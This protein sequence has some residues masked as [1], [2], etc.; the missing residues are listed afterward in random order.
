MLNLSPAQRERVEY[1]GTHPAMSRF[2]ILS[3]DRFSTAIR[4][5]AESFTDSYADTFT[6]TASGCIFHDDHVKPF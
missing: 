3:Q 2:T 5:E 1:I 6:I 4:V